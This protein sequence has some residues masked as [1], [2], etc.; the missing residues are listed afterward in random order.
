MSTNKPVTIPHD[1]ANAIETL[2]RESASDPAFDNEGIAHAY[3]TESYVG[4]IALNL[5][6]IPFDTLMRALLDG[7]E[8]ELTEEEKREQVYAKIREAYVKH[9]RREGDYSRGEQDSA[10]ADGIVFTLNA[11]GI[12]IPSVNSEADDTEV[13]ANV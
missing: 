6:K 7:Y 11:L 4:P 13:A 12:V 3:V 9:A 8:R 5:R 2:R 1:V 10:H